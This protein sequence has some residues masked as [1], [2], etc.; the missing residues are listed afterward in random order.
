MKSIRDLKNPDIVEINREKYQVINNTS[1]WYDNDKK[2][3]EMTVELVK[4]GTREIT[5]KYRLIYIYEKPEEIKFFVF[6]DKIDTWA[7]V[8]INELNF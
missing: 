3:L 1:L 6:S 4:V 2:Q 5:P 8:H 7:E